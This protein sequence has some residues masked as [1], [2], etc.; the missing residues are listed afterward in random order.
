MLTEKYHFLQGVFK[1]DGQLLAMKGAKNT[2]GGLIEGQ[3]K[4][5]GLAY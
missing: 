5:K 4:K 3:I 1:A 2:K